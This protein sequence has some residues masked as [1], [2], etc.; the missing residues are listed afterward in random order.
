VAGARA[1]LVSPDGALGRFPLPALP[2]QGPGR[3]LIEDMPIAVVPLPLLLP[4][5]RRPVAGADG[6]A[7]AAPLLLLGDIDFDGR[8]AGVQVAQGHAGGH[9][10]VRG[11]HDLHFQPLAGTA[12]EIDAIGALFRQSHAGS[13]PDVLRGAD[14][15]EEAFRDHVRGKRYVHL[16][17]HGF[18]ATPELRT[19][20]GEGAEDDRG[21]VLD[22][23]A[24]THPGLLSGLVLAG[25]NRGTA[26]GAE[27]R[28]PDDGILTALEVAELDLNRADLVVLSACETGLGEVADG[29][30][31]LGLQRAFQVAGARTVVASLWQVE[32]DATQRLMARYYEN[33]WQEQRS[34]LDA[35]RQAQLALL[36]EESEASPARAVGEPERAGGTPA[37]NPRRWAAWVLSGDPGDVAG[38][39]P[40]PV[41]VAAAQPSGQSATWLLVVGGGYSSALLLGACL[42]AWQV[43]RRRFRRSSAGA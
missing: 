25:A 39:E 9:V 22:S 14:A 32:D 13:T 34:P 29:E 17:T 4:A 12:R 6:D 5:D 3:Y 23:V 37:A 21:A 24:S 1:V 2:G 27:D 36:R 19:L 40:A 18:F 15:T 33:L 20:L 43:H 26:A 28:P 16:A 41:P 8:P 7:A 31:L 11:N 42:A 35:L 38:L 30:G 10:A